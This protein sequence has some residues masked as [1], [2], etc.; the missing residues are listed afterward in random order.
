MAEKS[1]QAERSEATRAALLAAAR[2]LFTERGYADV[3][4]EEIVSRARVTRGALYHHFEDKKDLFRAVHEANEE[5]LVGSIA[6]SVE[7]ITDPLEL[8]AAGI[9]SFLDACEDPALARIGLIEAPA[10]LGWEEWRAI[11]AKYG[12]GLVMGVLQAAI[13]AGVLE[14]VPVRTIGHLLLAA[15]GEA[16]IMVVSAEDPKAMRAEVEQSLLALL[17][18]LP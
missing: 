11:D 5:R 17:H 2:E 16:G 10:V 12:L 18:G 7:G 3:G 15:M 13:D 8:L 4:T 6:A 9:R 1:R 14:P